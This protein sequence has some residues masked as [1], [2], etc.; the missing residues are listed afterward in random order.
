MIKGGTPLVR[1]RGRPR[2]ST[3][4]RVLSETIVHAICEAKRLGAKDKIAAETAGIHPNTLR[5]WIAKATEEMDLRENGYPPNPH[6]DD[7]V[8]FLG[9]YRQS[10]TASARL[11]LQTLNDAA[12]TGDVK[13]AMWL[14]ERAHGYGTVQQMH[15]TGSNEDGS[16]GVKHVIEPLAASRI[17][18]IIPA[19]RIKVER[20]IE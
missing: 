11:A 18:G 4:G 6:N 13:A 5:G 9:K 3:F 16:I 14:L 20:E 15:I 12:K 2:K 19:A 10:S 1:K 7:Y 17:E 8:E